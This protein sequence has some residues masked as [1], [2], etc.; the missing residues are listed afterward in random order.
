LFLLRQNKYQDELLSRKDTR[1]S[2][3][4]EI[5]N[6]IRIIKLFAWE[7]RFEN[8]IKDMRKEELS[9]LKKYVYAGAYM[10]VSVNLFT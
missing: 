9:S 3:I 4:N 8:Q 1:M 10:N 2:C 7:D 6:S 5:L